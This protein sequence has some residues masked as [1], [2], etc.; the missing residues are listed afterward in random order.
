MVQTLLFKVFRYLQMYFYTIA[1]VL[2]LWQYISYFLW[3]ICMYKNASLP[4]NKVESFHQ[5]SQFFTFSWIQA[6]IFHLVVPFHSNF[7]FHYVSWFGHW[8]ATKERPAKAL[9][10]FHSSSFLLPLPWN[11]SIIFILMEELSRWELPKAPK[12]R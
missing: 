2:S 8:D 6:L 1:E 11:I 3:T 10:R 7:V 5:W 4:E 9:A 12:L